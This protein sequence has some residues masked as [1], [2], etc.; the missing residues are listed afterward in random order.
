[1]EE[2]IR[3]AARRR[4][5]NRKEALSFAGGSESNRRAVGKKPESRQ[6]SR[7]E[8]GKTGGKISS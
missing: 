2:K 8:E 4:S 3:Q 6:E 5:G 7:L 1:M